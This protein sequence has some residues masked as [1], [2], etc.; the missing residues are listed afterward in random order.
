[1]YP[2]SIIFDVSAKLPKRASNSYFR[3]FVLYGRAPVRMSGSPTTHFYQAV[4][5]IIR[6]MVEA[7]L[8]C[9]SLI[10]RLCLACVGQEH[11]PR[12]RANLVSYGE[13]M[14]MV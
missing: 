8:A 5:L 7:I 12:L 10:P 2:T 4:D 13:R 9:P 14:C 3:D 11:T 6:F 1:M